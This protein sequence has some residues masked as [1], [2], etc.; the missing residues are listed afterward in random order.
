MNLDEIIKLVH[1]VTGVPLNQSFSLE[2]RADLNDNRHLIW[3]MGCRYGVRN[4]VLARRWDVHPSTVSC[5]IARVETAPHER[6]GLA[7]KRERLRA[8][9]EQNPCSRCQ[10]S[11]V[12]P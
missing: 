3:W 2:K 7:E 12:E 4:H 9:S 5:G 10:G 8:L 6:N 11:G 1:R